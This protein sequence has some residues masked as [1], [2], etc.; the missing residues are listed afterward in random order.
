MADPDAIYELAQRIE[1]NIE[2]DKRVAALHSLQSLLESAGHVVEADAVTSAVK[3]ALRHANQ[4]LSTASL[5]FIPTYA[6][7]IYSGDATDSHSLLNHNVRMLVNS[8]GLLVIDKLGDQKERIREAARTALIELGNAAYAISSGHLTTSGKGKETETP[9]GIFERTLRE[10]G[11]AAKFARVREQSVLLLPI[12]RQSCEK[13]PIRP[14]LSTTVELLL[15]ADATVRE[16]ARSTLITLFSSATPAAKADLKKELEKR[17]VR[18]Q[19]ADAILREVLGAPSAATSAPVLSPPAPTTFAPTTRSQFNS[20]HGA[21]ASIPT[22]YMKSAPAAGTTFPSMP[23][24][25]ATAAADGIRPVYIASRSDLERTFT[26]MMPFFENKE[27]EHNWLNREQ[28]M[29]KI[30]GLLVSGAHRQFGE[31]LFVAQLK[32]VQEGIL[33]CIS[34]LRT[35]LSMH[36]IH[37]VQELAMEL[38]DDLAPCVEAF[39]IHLVGMAGFTKKLIANATQEAAAAIMVNVSFRPLYLQLIWQA[40]Q[41]KNVATRTAAAEHLCTVLN[42]HAA[43]R[44]HAVESHGGLDLLEKCMRKG[45]GDSNPAARTKSREAFWIFHRHWAAQANALLN[46]LDPAIRKQVA[47]LAPSDVE[48]D[49]IVEQQPKADGGPVRVRPGGASMALIQAKKA[50]ALKAAQERDRKK[51]EDAAAAHEARVAAA[52]AALAE[53]QQQQQQV[54][55]HLE[56][57][58]SVE[59]FVTP[60][61]ANNKKGTGFMPIKNRSLHHPGG[62]GAGAANL[63]PATELTVV[64]SPTAHQR[65]QTAI[66][67]PLPT[68]PTPAVTPNARI[69]SK[70][71]SQT[72]WETPP[73]PRSPGLSPVSARS[74]AISSSSYSSQGSSSSARMQGAASTPRSNR[75]PPVTHSTLKADLE[76]LSIDGI[77]GIDDGEVTADATQQARFATSS[78]DNGT[79]EDDTLQMNAP[80][81]ASMDLMGMDFN[82][83][84]KMP[85]SGGRAVKTQSVLLERQNALDA[86]QQ[87]PQPKSHRTISTSSTSSTNSSTTPASASV[88]RSG[89]PR[90]VSTMHSP[91]PSASASHISAGHIHA[92]TT[93]HRVLSSTPS[94]RAPT[95][96]V[97]TAL[98]NRAKRLDAQASTASASPAKAKPEVWTWIQAL[99]DGTADLRTFRR[100]ARLSSEFGISAT[101]AADERTEQDDEMVLERGPFSNVAWATKSDGAFSSGLQAW[102]EGGLF[103]KL[104]DGLK[105]YLCVGDGGGSGELQMS[106]QVV[107]LRLVENQFSLFGATDRE[108]ELL[109]VVL[110]SI[111]L[112]CG[113]RTSCVA[114][115]SIVAGRA[116]LQGF[117]SILGAWSGRCDPVLGFDALL[118][119]SL[120]DASTVAVLRSGFT[121]LLVRLPAQLVLE[122]FLPRLAPLLTSTLHHASPEKRLTAVTVLR[123]LNDM[124][125]IDAQDSHTRIFDALGLTIRDDDDQAELK[126]KRALLD[127]LMYYFSK[128]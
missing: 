119:R 76:N 53:Q 65:I 56:Q 10:A 46:S 91:S 22:S 54:Q 48:T 92:P 4:A 18:K 88:R 128:N 87:T 43:H 71:L 110:Q 68:S 38:G 74:R 2:V 77:D 61:A 103:G 5:S 108:G 111:T 1:S 52:R 121:P 24:A 95:N 40:F 84:F 73:H 59:D 39:L 13:Y 20:S 70:N 90:P 124:V 99:M 114:S 69:K 83:P 49:T 45:V 33:K 36:A 116:A 37:L 112:L 17:A 100:L 94:R 15:D 21:D 42:T 35:T 113:T 107:L 85:A 55:K 50:A 126:S 101:K 106:A 27:S 19:T 109:D 64:I 41:E 78:R 16:G 80:E 86:L 60:V 81:D 79:G 75:A 34:S 98:E 66:S 96:G 26:T 28:S 9:L 23:S 29:I 62:Q 58:A 72:S 97:S 123:H 115:S 67:V 14:L 120:S 30:R 63:K 105:R 8:V 6:S 93:S 118:S 122:D 127:V 31:T 3:V 12:L 57:Q 125:R 104:F 117:E 89:L 51:A 47:A 82:S 11:L 7:M 44:K 25:S 102:L 32:A